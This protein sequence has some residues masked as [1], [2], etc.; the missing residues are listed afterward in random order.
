MPQKYLVYLKN[1]EPLSREEFIYEDV[2]Y[3]KNVSFKQVDDI[4]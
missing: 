1:C 4:R 3:Y 2:N